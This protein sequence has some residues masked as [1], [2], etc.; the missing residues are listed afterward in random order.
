MSTLT[1]LAGLPAKSAREWIRRNV[2]EA[3]VSGSWAPEIIAGGLS[4][5]TYR[6]IGRAH[7]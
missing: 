7:V 1:D 4:N 6:Q 3:D 5:I 2:P